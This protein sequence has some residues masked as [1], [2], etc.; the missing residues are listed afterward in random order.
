M[1]EG[2]NDN[3]QSFNHSISQTKTLGALESLA[4]VRMQELP[5]EVWTTPSEATVFNRVRDWLKSLTTERPL[6]YD[7]SVTILGA[8][9]AARDANAVCPDRFASKCLCNEVYLQHRATAAGI[10]SRQEPRGH[11]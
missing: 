7:S 1:N 9:V 5:L 10:I 8:I 6:P 4:A 2:M 3:S 11:Q